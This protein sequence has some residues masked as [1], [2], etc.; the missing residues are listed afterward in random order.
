MLRQIKISDLCNE[1]EEKLIELQYSEYSMQEYRK[2]FREFKEYEI[3][4]TT[5][6]A[7]GLLHPYKGLIPACARKA[8]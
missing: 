7:G 2:V 4:R 3:V 5:G 1:L 6:V 8:H